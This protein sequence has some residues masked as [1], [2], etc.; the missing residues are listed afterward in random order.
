M[1]WYNDNN[2]YK[3]IVQVKASSF[4]F[5]VIGRNVWTSCLSVVQILKFC[6]MNIYNYCIKEWMSG[7]SVAKMIYSNVVMF[8][9]H[10][11][12]LLI[13]KSRVLFTNYQLKEDFI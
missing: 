2:G 3:K 13:T 8:T 4:L 5:L 9:S 10:V 12:L 6:R 1:Q 7:F 11:S